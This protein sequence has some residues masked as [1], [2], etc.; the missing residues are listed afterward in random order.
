MI[1]GLLQLKSLSS[2]EQFKIILF[3][4]IGSLVVTRPLENMW[5]NR[6]YHGIYPRN[7][8]PHDAKI[9]KSSPE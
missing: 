6:E 4:P 2:M 3:L 9:S 8:Y 5:I 7:A 1:F